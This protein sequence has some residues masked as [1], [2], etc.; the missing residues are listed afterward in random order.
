MDNSRIVTTGVWRSIEKMGY[1]E[2]IGRK[3]TETRLMGLMMLKMSKREFTLMKERRVRN[4]GRALKQSVEA[5]R[6]GEERAA[7]PED[8]SQM[9][10]TNT[11]SPVIRLSYTKT[12][13]Q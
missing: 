1:K 10:E 4:R 3:V 12:S 13:Y 6:S 8:K 5:S 7:G 11:L 9:E 2:V